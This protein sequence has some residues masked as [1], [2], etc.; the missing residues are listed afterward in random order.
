MRTR[1]IVAV[2]LAAVLAFTSISF[3]SIGLKA[4]EVPDA[5]ET[6]DEDTPDV[7]DVSDE[8]SDTVE[9]DFEDDDSQDVNTPLIGEEDQTDLT[10]IDAEAL[11]AD[12]D[13]YTLTFNAN[14]GV[15]LKEIKKT[16]D[17][18]EYT[19]HYEKDGT[20]KNAKGTEDNN[21]VDFSRYSFRVANEDL[22]KEFD[23]WWTA[24]SGGEC[25][26]QYD[27]YSSLNVSEFGSG[28]TKTLYAHWKD[29]YNVV[30]FD[31]GEDNTLSYFD[32]IYS[33]ERT[34]QRYA[35]FRI[36]EN[37]TPDGNP[38]DMKY[39][40]DSKVFKTWI[41][42]G[43]EID[44]TIYYYRIKGTGDATLTA[45]YVN[46][47]TVIA[48]YGEGYYRT[49]EWT[50]TSEGWKYSDPIY[51]DLTL[52]IAEG[53]NFSGVWD[54]EIDKEG[55]VFDAWYYDE[56]YTKKADLLNDTVTGDCEIWARYAR[57]YTYTFDAG[58]GYFYYDNVWDE[59]LDEYK[60]V[61][62][63]KYEIKEVGGTKF[64]GYIYTPQLKDHYFDKW[65]IGDDTT[66]TITTEEIKDLVA[67]SDMTFHALYSDPVIVV[68]KLEGGNINGSTS[69]VMIKVKKGGTLEYA[70]GF[71]A[72][73]QYAGYEF[74]GWYYGK[75][76]D[77][78]EVN[79]YSDKIF[80][81]TT[82]YARYRKLY[83]YTFNANGGTIYGEPTCVYEI[84]EG[85]LFRYRGEVPRDSEIEA[86]EGKAFTGWYTDATCTQKVERYQIEKTY[87]SQNMI[88]WAGW[89]DAYTV[90]FNATDGEFDGE[91]KKQYSV[92]VAKG[93]DIGRFLPNIKAPEDKVFKGWF[94]DETLKNEIKNPYEYLVSGNVNIYAGWTDCFAITFH[95]NAQGA[96]FDNGSDTCKIKVVKG[97]V[98]RYVP[99]QS[100][101]ACL[102][103]PAIKTYPTD[104]F[105]IDKWYINSAC[106]GDRYVLEADSS[107]RIDTDG[108]IVELGVNGYVPTSDMDFYA[109]W[110][111]ESVSVTFDANGGTFYY[112]P[113]TYKG[114][115]NDDYTR[116]S[117]KVAKGTILD[118]AYNSIPWISDYPE[119][120]NENNW[121][122]KNM[123]C[124]EHLEGYTPVTEDITVYCKWV[125]NVPQDPEETID[126]LFHAGDG[127][128]YEDYK[129]KTEEYGLYKSTTEW[130]TTPIA[131]I[132][133][134]DRAFYGWY[135]DKD[136]KNPIP[137]DRITYEDSPH[138][139]ILFAESDFGITDLYAGYGQAYKVNIYANGG[140][141]GWGGGSMELYPSV[142]SREET[143]DHIKLGRLEV[144]NISGYTERIR[145]DGDLL[146]GGW[147]TDAACTTPLVT[148]SHNGSTFFKPT[149]FET[150][151]YAKWIEYTPVKS[152][153]VSGSN[154]VDKGK[155]I[156][157][158]ATVDPSSAKDAVIWCTGYEDTIRLE[159]D[160]TVYG[161]NEG[162]AVVYAFAHGVVSNKFKV[163]VTAG[164]DPVVAVTK[165]EI[166]G[167][168]DIGI[169]ATLQLTGKVLPSNATDKT[170][171]WKSSSD[172]IA[173]VDSSGLVTAK[174]T[175]KVDITATS[176]Q[177]P[178]KSA[179]VSITV[180]DNTPKVKSVKINYDGNGELN[181]GKTLTLTADVE[182][183]KGADKTVIWSTSDDK[184]ATVSDAGLVTAVAAGKVDITATSKQDASKSAT[185][186]L[187]IKEV[188]PK[189]NSIKIT[190][191]G[192]NVLNI[193]MTIALTA[194]VEA[195]AGAD[196]TVTWS[197]S[198]DKVATVSAEGLVTAVG[199]G[200]AVIKA[201]AGDKEASVTVE[202]LSVPVSNIKIT[203]YS[204]EPIPMQI[205]DTVQLACTVSPANATDSSVTWSSSDD[206]VVT[207]D[208]KG[209]IT[210]VANGEA[211]IRATANDG[212][213]VSGSVKVKVANVETTA[214]KLRAIGGE[215]M[216]PGSSQQLDVV[217]VPSNATNKELIWSTDND[218]V[219]I[220][221]DGL[222]TIKPENEIEWGDKTSIDVVIT[223]KASESVQASITLTV[224]K[225]VKPVTS[226]SIDA[227]AYKEG[228]K[229]GDTFRLT[230]VIN[231]ADATNKA[232]TWSSSENKVA[233]VDG[234]GLVTINGFGTTDI[235]VTAA[236]SKT[237]KYTLKVSKVAVSSVTILGTGG[238]NYLAVGKSTQLA[239]SVKPD[240]ASVTDIVWTTSDAKIATVDVAGNITGV[241]AG[242]VTLKA[243]SKDD[244]SKNASVALTVFVDSDELYV[245]FA[246]GSDF[247]YNGNA[248][249]PKVNVFN[250][251]RL[252]VQDVDYTVKY[253]N[254]KNA[255][256]A[257]DPSKAPKVTVT[258]KTIA[259]TAEATFRIQPYDIGNEDIVAG[260]VLIASGK[261]AKPILYFGGTKLGPKDF[262]N[263]YEKEKFYSSRTITVFGK[264]NFTGQREVW[265]S[266]KD[267]AK[268][269]KA[270]PKIKVQSFKPVK[271]TYNGQP[272]KLTKG[273]LVV[274]SATDK[275]KPA[276]ALVENVDYYIAYPDDI[277][278]AG[279]KTISI[280]GV[281]DYTGSATKNYTI[282][283]VAQDNSIKSIDISFP[284]S[285]SEVNGV[286]AFEYVPGGVRPA[287]EIIV[288]RNNGS[289]DILSAGRD[290]KVKYTNNTKATIV[291]KN[292][293]ASADITFTGNYKN[294]GKRSKAFYVEQADLANAYTFSQDKLVASK[295]DQL[296]VV[297]SA[298]TVDIEGVTVAP[299]E[300]QVTFKIE[301]KAVS[302][303]NMIKLE[304]GESVEVEVFIKAK[305]D[306]TGKECGNYTGYAPTCSYYI[307]RADKSKDLS[308]A[309]VIIQKKG[310]NS[311]KAVGRIPFTGKSIE[312]GSADSAYEFHVTLGNKVLVEGKDFYVDYSN[313]VRAGTAKVVLNGYGDTY[314]GSKSFM[315]K[316]VK[317]RM[318]W[319][320]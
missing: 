277:T 136:L 230:A 142:I 152:I 53:S 133:D 271:R 137:D 187:T 306:K 77:A 181:V 295:K 82:I 223:A 166:T 169:G 57:E 4:A 115:Y 210:A 293:K 188:L 278:S 279:K 180:T 250:R 74:E 302:K 64:D 19:D 254:N 237:A 283:A 106:T 144:V 221:N 20:T 285:V 244:P 296:K 220:V 150:N 49:R 161:V 16:Q 207:V 151:I 72:D 256:D 301:D 66:K 282:D 299:G 35:K 31:A 139:M 234:T 309:K 87:V 216:V 211:T 89:R 10:D 80:E 288:T 129:R 130:N 167:A 185:V 158:T 101:Y 265:I 135:Y 268:K 305:T 165:V 9:T 41:D 247:T 69:D 132:L 270:V 303:K 318:R 154:T 114:I 43:E 182:A 116:Y 44:N 240:N 76:E 206:K 149:S 90:T 50:G 229:P 81:N 75:D 112:S 190:Y 232:V 276:K 88:Y 251:G 62:V 111:D 143:A 2:L 121:Y 280:V 194:E 109:K 157:L 262:S 319:S 222:V 219:A 189:V 231:P 236:D 294:L 29:A 60:E 113:E 201:K 313:N 290:Y 269:L 61:P 238:D 40:D 273:E 148:Y 204:A 146:F 192:S 55:W 287:L 14:G 83:K 174:A 281:G 267:D 184:I 217:I 140:Y 100:D 258:G 213:K 6:V 177:N 304:S 39:K 78:K 12:G 33:I 257:S 315:F 197:S 297:E 193:G 104:K 291:N 179:T 224:M 261:T 102:G 298:P 118:N 274:V 70:D 86:P 176:K 310:D 58:E 141:F 34:G 98:L 205:G 91:D 225:P 105:F 246:E 119:G 46:N 127:C 107:Y 289:S 128:F 47:C 145:R 26:F 195:D 316:I 11:N 243:A 28:K 147:Y 138:C 84:P 21:S 235:T 275:S 124:T 255:N 22:H 48:H 203:G 183:D 37:R 248:I 178:D 54:A 42:D 103:S 122:Y 245:Q 95:T 186:S 120:Y 320:K 18:Y 131:T 228:L 134:N 163:T 59:D 199:K 162:T 68:A 173:T 153:T 24:S 110:T 1:R 7:E 96:L 227:K 175:G 226:V 260:E 214:V 51:G 125:K 160:G 3:D 123:E 15:F 242:K 52:K 79:N 202:V 215:I 17:G 56:D 65:Y 252:L 292:K 196:K 264:G 312:I 249:T 63:T 314:Y 92:V 172:A 97:D 67:E 300:Y 36:A 259:S 164:S 218:K 209:L 272:Q 308:A 27:Y 159:S 117:V 25:V 30:T 284:D 8:T 171:I 170:L 168:K 200:K 266:V 263:P 126:V 212:S 307:T 191:S 311:H 156:K 38:S 241:S 155:S 85:G 73:P 23:G 93:C 253:S 99:A 94:S 5:T 13:E 317:G 233:S 71:P 32:P 198:D 208:D 239:V 108:T 45:K 286:D